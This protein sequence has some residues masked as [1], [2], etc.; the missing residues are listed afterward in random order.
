M[1]KTIKFL[2][3]IVLSAVVAFAMACIVLAITDSGKAFAFTYFIGASII[4]LAMGA[5]HE[6][7]KAKCESIKHRDGRHYGQA[8]IFVGTA[9][10]FM[11][12]PHD[13]DELCDDLWHH[14]QQARVEM[15]TENDVDFNV[16]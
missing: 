6:R 2:A 11:G 15:L 9:C 1:K 14:G 4:A 16:L 5:F 13:C 3:I 10:V 7:S 8:A 12:T